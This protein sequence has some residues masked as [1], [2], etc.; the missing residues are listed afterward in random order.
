MAKAVKPLARLQCLCLTTCTVLATIT[1]SNERMEDIVGFRGSRI[2]E[3][4]SY[5]SLG[6]KIYGSNLVRPQFYST[7]ILVSMIFRHVSTGQSSCKRGVNKQK[8]SC[9]IVRRLHGI[10]Q[11][12]GRIDVTPRLYGKTEV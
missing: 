11:W 2:R 9:V 7:S 6:L 12:K 10:F 3:E 4:A 1:D 5:Y 8:K